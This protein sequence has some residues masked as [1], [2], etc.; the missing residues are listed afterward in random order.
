MKHP[1]KHLRFPEAAVET[2][3]EL[4]QVSGQMFGADTMMNTPNITFNIGNRGMDPGQDLG[5]LLPRTGD[6]PLMTETG[7]SVQE[8]VALPAVG[9]DHPSAA[10]RSRTKG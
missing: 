9:L 6:Q 10:R 5:R 1:V 8:T 2:V 3:T 7:S 4:P